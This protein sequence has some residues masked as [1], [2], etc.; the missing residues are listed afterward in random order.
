MDGTQDRCGACHGVPPRSGEHDEHDRVGCGSCHGGSYTTA[1]A[2]KAL[3]FNGALDV[4]GTR[5]RS[6]DPASR[7]C[8]PTCH[9]AESWDDGG[10]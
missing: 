10:G 7:R 5:I 8:Q 1:V 9:E 2:D 3:H 6:W 4:R